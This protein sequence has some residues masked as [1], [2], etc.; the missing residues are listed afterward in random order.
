[1]SK[2]PRT[3]L[4]QTKNL[5]SGSDE[6]LEFPKSMSNKLHFA[7]GFTSSVLLPSHHPPPPSPPPPLFFV[8]AARKLRVNSDA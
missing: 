7:P 4:V 1:M 2:G 6:G 8:L 3:E 5:L